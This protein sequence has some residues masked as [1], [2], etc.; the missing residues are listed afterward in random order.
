MMHD[1]CITETHAVFMDLPLILD[2]SALMSGKLPL[3]FKKEAG[4]K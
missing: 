4:A 3:V 1:F 2:P